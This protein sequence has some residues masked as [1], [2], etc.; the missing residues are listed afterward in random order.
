[1][2]IVAP[3]AE[4]KSFF[5]VALSLAM[6]SGFITIIPSAKNHM[7]ILATHPHRPQSQAIHGKK[8]M[9]C[10]DYKKCMEEYEMLGHTSVYRLQKIYGGI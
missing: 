1:M 5:F 4:K 9:L 10:T 3:T 6:K 8:L 2:R 7:D